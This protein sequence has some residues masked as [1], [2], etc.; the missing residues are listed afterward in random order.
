[1]SITA[2]TLIEAFFRV[3]TRSVVFVADISSSLEMQKGPQHQLGAFRKDVPAV[4][5]SP[6]PC[7][8]Q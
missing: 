1:M 3:A 8:V 5:Y 6:T 2:D 4:S 7:R